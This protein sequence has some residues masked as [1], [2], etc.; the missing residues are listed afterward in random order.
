MAKKQSKEPNG[1]RLLC[2]EI[3]Q[4]GVEIDDEELQRVERFAA[5][6]RIIE[7]SPLELSDD[8]LEKAE[9]MAA[10]LSEVADGTGE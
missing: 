4:S 6:L 3:E 2:S 1:M 10:A 8:E 7:D 9:R 5:A